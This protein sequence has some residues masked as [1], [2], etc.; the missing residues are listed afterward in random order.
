MVHKQ[1]AK[2]LI[3]IKSEPIMVE[4]WLLDTGAGISCM[5]SQQFRLFPIERRPTKLN[6]D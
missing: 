6:L 5:S 2:K 4:K 3:E 1:D